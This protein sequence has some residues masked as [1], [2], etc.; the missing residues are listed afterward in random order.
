[1]RASTVQFVIEVLNCEG[2]YAEQFDCNVSDYRNVREAKQY[3]ANLAEGYR[4]LGFK[5][6]V[7]RRAS[8][9]APATVVNL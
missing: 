3:A 6:V 8:S 2:T 1:M 7:Y 9:L 5:V 4:S